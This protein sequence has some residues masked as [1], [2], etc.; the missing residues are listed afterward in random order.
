MQNHEDRID[1]VHQSLVSKTNLGVNWSSPRVGGRCHIKVFSTVIN[2]C[3]LHVYLEAILCIP[4]Y[5]H[6]YDSNC[7][8]HCV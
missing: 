1:Y 5:S 7:N 3:F 6:M 8:K 4:T 2:R